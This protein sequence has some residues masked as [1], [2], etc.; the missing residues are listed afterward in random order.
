M[1]LLV[2]IRICKPGAAFSLYVFHEHDKL[3]NKC[4]LNKNVVN[5]VS[6]IWLCDEEINLV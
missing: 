2:L 5:A 4:W 3:Y 6:Y 1:D